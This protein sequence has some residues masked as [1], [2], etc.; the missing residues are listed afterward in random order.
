MKKFQEA[1][2]SYGLT[3]QVTIKAVTQP[4]N[5]YSWEASTS[6]PEALSELRSPSPSYGRDRNSPK[7]AVTL[8]QGSET[9]AP[10]LNK[11]RAVKPSYGRNLGIGFF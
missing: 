9:T 6:V 4:G 2:W 11:L 3:F 7:E 1:S 5:S 8:G 10:F